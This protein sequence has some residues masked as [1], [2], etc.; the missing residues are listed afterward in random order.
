[1]I[2][3]SDKIVLEDDELE[4][5]FMR[6]SGPGGQHVNKSETGVQLR[7]NA[8]ESPSLPD[9]VRVRLRRLAGKQWTAE[10]EIVIEATRFRSQKANRE[11]AVDRLISLV[12]QAEAKPKRR[13]KT[14]PTKASKERR[15]Q[16][17]QR[18]SDVKRTRGPV[19]RNDD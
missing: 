19:R 6:S 15:L 14:R 18:R 9:D 17:K 3:V 4:E 7:F 1:M 5:S 2:R 10:G 13:K 12:R 11:D 8:G 16:E